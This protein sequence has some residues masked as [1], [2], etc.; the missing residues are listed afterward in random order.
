[1]LI[2][3]SNFRCFWHTFQYAAGSDDLCCLPLADLFFSRKASLSV[4]D[5]SI[6]FTCAIFMVSP[7]LSIIWGLSCVSK[8]NVKNSVE[9]YSIIDTCLISW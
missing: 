1:M 6:I 2:P 5:G 8:V 4:F 3:K 7:K 9:K